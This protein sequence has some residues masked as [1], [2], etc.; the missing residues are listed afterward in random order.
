M[1]RIQSGGEDYYIRPLALR[2]NTIFFNHLVCNHAH[3][4]PWIGIVN[5]MKTLADTRTYLEYHIT[6]FDKQQGMQAGIFSRD[7]LVGCVSF[8]GVDR[9]SRKLILGYWLDV[10]WQ[11]RGIMTSSIR[12]VI[13]YAFT[14]WN[15]NRIEARCASENIRSRAIPQ[16]LGFVE[17]GVM[18]QGEW[19]GGRYTDQVIYALL[20]EKYHASKT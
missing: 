3:L 14:Q 18:H 4:Y 15:I 16:R 8:H 9:I 5:R 12:S 7:A 10:Q 6:L 13:E 11:G 19:V 2:D 1:L 20:R 17:E